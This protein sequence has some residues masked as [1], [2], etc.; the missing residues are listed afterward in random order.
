M[1]EGRCLLLEWERTWLYALVSYNIHGLL[2][3]SGGDL[4]ASAAL[5]LTSFDQFGDVRL[6]HRAFQARPRLCT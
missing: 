2:S 3:C 1:A 6:I 5:L 4:R